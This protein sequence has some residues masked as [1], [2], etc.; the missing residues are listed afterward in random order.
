MRTFLTATVLVAAL[1]APALAQGQGGYAP[2]VPGADTAA[3]PRDV[4]ADM[5]YHHATNDTSGGTSS[6]DKSGTT[7]EGGGSIDGAQGRDQALG[8]HAPG[9]LGAKTEPL[10]R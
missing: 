1:A 8:A 7:Q 3:A 4:V 10:D 6:V 5:R 9:N 2:G